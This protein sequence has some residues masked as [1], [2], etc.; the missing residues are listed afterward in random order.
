MGRLLMAISRVEGWEGRLAA[1]V[2]QAR[3]RPHQWGVFD[4]CLA[5][6]DGVREITGVDPATALRG[7]YKTERGALLA[8]RRFAGGG[9]VETVEKIAAD[10]GAPEVGTGF[11]SRGDVVLV[12]D[13]AVSRADFGGF[14][15][16]CLGRDVA[17]M[18]LEGL[19]LWPLEP[20]W[21][22]WKV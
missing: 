21:R 2:A 20:D 7:R 8:L 9:L 18:T 22:V 6:C 5:P 4:C 13:P 11:A 19:R 16:L 12:T 3:S 17:V 10:L 14:L 1:F 15:G